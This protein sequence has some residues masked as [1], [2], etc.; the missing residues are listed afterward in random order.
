MILS[1]PLLL[2]LVVTLS[3]CETQRH[4]SGDALG[5][6]APLPTA[7]ELLHQ[8]DATVQRLRHVR[9]VLADRSVSRQQ[10][11]GPSEVLIRWHELFLNDND[12]QL[13]SDWILEDKTDWW[14]SFAVS[15]VPLTGETV[16]SFDGIKLCYRPQGKL[17]HAEIIN[18]SP[19][20][21][22][23]YLI[24]YAGYSSPRTL[25]IFA[26]LLVP[27]RLWERPDLNLNGG[28]LLVD[29]L[30]RTDGK[31]WEIIGR[32]RLTNDNTIKVVIPIS[33]GPFV[34]ELKNHDGKLEM[35]SVWYVWFT[36]DQHHF[37]VRI[38]SDQRYVYDG[39]TIPLIYA[40]DGRP[41]P[42]YSANGYKDFGNGL[43][44]PESG[45]EIVYSVAAGTGPGPTTGAI[46]DAIVDEYLEN[47]HYTVSQS[48][49]PSLKR[50]WKALAIE[51][52]DSSTSLWIEPPQG[53][54]FINVDTGVEQIIGKTVEETSEILRLRNKLNRILTP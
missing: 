6:T 32:E 27:G 30:T 15:K 47:G 5:P 43:W 49:F 42:I 14:A 54:M 35:S 17:N 26:P 10:P 52:I 29:M 46:A 4:D 3:G 12:V 18:V 23:P 41:G 34:P 8:L 38:E 9:V 11:D 37:P 44:Y 22:L 16:S 7:N 45:K 28:L 24:S 33:D 13:R 1:R 19:T 50:E 39:R 36:D 2:F 21:E 40:T 48:F 20:K 25:G 31:R 51:E 53:A